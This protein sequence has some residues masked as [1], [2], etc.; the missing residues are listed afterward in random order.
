MTTIDD[1]IEY[2]VQLFLAAGTTVGIN[3]ERST[4]G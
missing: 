4:P 2:F 3:H 1:I